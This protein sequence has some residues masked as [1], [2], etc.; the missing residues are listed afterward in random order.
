MTLFRY[1]HEH[2]AVVKMSGYLKDNVPNPTTRMSDDSLIFHRYK[3]V[4]WVSNQGGTINQAAMA[5]SVN[6]TENTRLTVIRFVHSTLILAGVFG[7]VISLSMALI[8]AAGL[9]GTPEG[10]KEMGTI[11]GGM[12][13]ALS[14]T[15]TAI[16]CFF[17]FAYFYMRLNDSRIRLLNDIEDVTSLYMIPKV[18]HTEESMV[19]HV[20]ELTNSLNEAANKLIQVEHTFM[21][22]GLTLQNAVNDLHGQIANSSLNEIKDLIRKGFHLSEPQYDVLQESDK[23]S[24][25]K[26]YNNKFE[27]PPENDTNLLADAQEVIGSEKSNIL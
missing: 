4:Q 22:A 7:T 8:G 5:S 21:N 13:S 16:F 15:I 10:V 3:A 2:Q 25:N 17:I 11:I 1:I 6:A 9:L 27:N 19:R 23:G 14:S 12:S 18:S 26:I 24:G 20:V